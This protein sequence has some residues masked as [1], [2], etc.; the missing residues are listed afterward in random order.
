MKKLHK[1]RIFRVSSGITL[2]SLGNEIITSSDKEAQRIFQLVAENQSK[3]GLPV[4][5][6]ALYKQIHQLTM[7]EN[8]NNSENCPTH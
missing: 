7:E 5:H 1:Y 4:G 2:E 6:L 8:E 3:A